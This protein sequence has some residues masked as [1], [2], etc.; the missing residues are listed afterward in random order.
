MR[1]IPLTQNKF[2]LVDDDVY[3]WAKDYNWY[4]KYTN[5]LWYVARNSSIKDD[6]QHKQHTIW[7]HHCIIGFPLSNK[8]VDHIDGNGLNNQ[9]SNLRF[10]TGRQNQQN[11][12]KHR[13]GRLVG[14]YMFKSN[15][16]DKTYIY[17]AAQIKINGKTTYLGLYPTEQ[18]AHD[19]YLKALEVML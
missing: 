1:Q 8:E 6:V 9:R 14:A 11:A 7:L 13:I 12:K 17:W 15:Y 18:E 3:E 2:A 16:K 10:T 5:N 4:A 19:A